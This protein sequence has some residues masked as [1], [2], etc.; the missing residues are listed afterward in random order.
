MKLAGA[1]LASGF[2]H[3]FQ[4]DKLNVLLRGKPLLSWSA[5]A[6]NFF[7]FRAVVLRPEQLRNV[8]LPVDASVLV[9]R[10][11]HLGMSE[12]LKLA[13]SWTPSDA[14][15]L[16]VMLADMPF[17]KHVVKLLVEVFREKRYSV[18][19]AGLGG[20][21]VNPAV[22]SRSVFQELLKLEGDVGARDVFHRVDVYVVDFP[23]GLLLDV[24]TADDL[25][26]AEEIAE[27][28]GL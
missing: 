14:D 6:L 7:E 2:S 17:V 11:A 25:A 16:A 10:R 8:I 26:K 21:P 1:V 12:A 22:F 20:R 4:S 19:A 28:R 27:S 23:E 13:V 15:G 24:D 3:R 18:V 9:N 5:E